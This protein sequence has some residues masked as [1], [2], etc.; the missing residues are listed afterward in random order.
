MPGR[1][2]ACRTLLVRSCQK[3]YGKPYPYF[4]RVIREEGT[5]SHTPTWICHRRVRQAVPLLGSVIRKEGTASRTPTWICH[6]Q[7]RVR[8]AIPLFRLCH[9]Q[10]GYGKPYPYRL[11]SLHWRRA[12]LTAKSIIMNILA[13]GVPFC[14][15]QCYNK[16]WRRH[17]AITFWPTS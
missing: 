3:G 11:S 14:H 1:G 8:Q 15:T 6:T 13:L 9:T 10:R 16:H 12:C 2:T 7:R 5:A 17:E 4:D